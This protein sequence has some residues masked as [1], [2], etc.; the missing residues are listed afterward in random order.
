M[1]VGLR[2]D[3][4]TLV[5]QSTDS[6]AATFDVPCPHCGVR[7]L[8]ARGRGIHAREHAAYVA[9]VAD[10]DCVV[11]SKPVGVLRVEVS[12]IFGID[13]DERVLNGRCRVY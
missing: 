5:A 8:R 3:E 2:V 9:Y 12:T 1:K 4:R 6:Q 10:A 11:C 13:E 7:P